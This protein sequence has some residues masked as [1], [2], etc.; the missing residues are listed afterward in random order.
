MKYYN[1]AQK[2][3]PADILDRIDNAIFKLERS[4]YQPNFF[5]KLLPIELG[6]YFGTKLDIECKNN[7]PLV[8]NDIAPYYYDL[9]EVVAKNTY[10]SYDISPVFDSLYFGKC[11]YNEDN[12]I[13]MINLNKRF[14][15]LKIID[16]ISIIIMIYDQAIESVKNDNI[17]WCPC[18]F[19]NNIL[20]YET[21]KLVRNSD[22]NQ[23][24]QLKWKTE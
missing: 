10:I 21:L 8:L 7:T 20:L 24:L 16:L 4:I 17:N 9:H 18:M 2:K 19:K 13:L 6:Y 15:E 5:N 3:L 1:K 22:D 11:D 12:P 14:E 23:V